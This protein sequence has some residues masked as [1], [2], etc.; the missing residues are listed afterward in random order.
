[1]LRSGRVKNDRQSLDG[2][3]QHYR[4]NS[5]AVVEAT[6]HWMVMYD[7]LDDICD[8]VVLGPAP[9]HP[10]SSIGQSM[11]QFMREESVRYPIENTATAAISAGHLLHPSRHFNHPREVLAAKDIGKEEKRAILASWASDIYAIESIPALRLYPGTDKAVSYYEIIE[12]LKALDMA[13]E[14]CGHQGAPDS[15]TAYKT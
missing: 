1:M 6:R 3:L 4:E 2:F 15:P 13:D 5:H 7:W 12:A 8:D 11:E 10:T 14:Q 9:Q